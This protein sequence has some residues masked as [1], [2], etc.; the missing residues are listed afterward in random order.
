MTLS[1][2][3]KIWFGKNESPPAEEGGRAVAALAPKE[4]KP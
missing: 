4:K 3:S 2:P 1:T